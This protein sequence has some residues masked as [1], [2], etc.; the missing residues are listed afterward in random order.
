MIKVNILKKCY[1]IYKEKL[2]IE[3]EI[4]DDYKVAKQGLIIRVCD[5]GDELKFAE[6]N[7]P[8][9]IFKSAQDKGLCE[10]L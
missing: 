9:Q 1:W 2:S 4:V 6:L 8:S 7:F 10:V 3:Q 5:V